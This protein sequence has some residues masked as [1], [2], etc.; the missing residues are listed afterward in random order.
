MERGEFE[1]LE[2]AGRPLRDIDGHYDP[3][4]WLRQ[5]LQREQLTGE[6]ASI[7]VEKLC[8]RRFQPA[9]SSRAP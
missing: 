1:Y 3:D 8:S 6:D 5:K 2:G 4:W 9:K 7:I